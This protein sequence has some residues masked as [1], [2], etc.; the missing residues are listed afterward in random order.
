MASSSMILG[1]LL[2]AGFLTLASA[3]GNATT[4]APSGG[5]ATQ[6]SGSGGNNT[7]CAAKVS[8]C[9][10]EVAGIISNVTSLAG[11][12]L[13]G[14]LS[15]TNT[16]KTLCLKFGTVEKCVK[17]AADSADCSGLPNT[18]NDYK[19]SVSVPSICNKYI[20][21]SGHALPNMAVV[22]ASILTAMLVGK[23]F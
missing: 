11:Q 18:L 1:V 10:S 22:M 20:S 8:A 21:G 12:I 3:A 4:A 16:L 9:S 5:N 14:G 13:T 23:L 19:K 17:T 2:M 6:A 15:I 7:A